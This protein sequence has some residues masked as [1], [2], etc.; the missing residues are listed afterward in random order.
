MNHSVKLVLVDELREYSNNSNMHP[1]AQLIQLAASL[2]EFGMAGALVVRDGVIGKGHGTLAAIKRLYSDGKLL[3]PPPGKAQG[4]QPYPAGMVPVIDA[5]GWT[6]AQF[7]AYVIADN[8]LGRMSEYD[9]QILAGEISSLLSE[10][11]NTDLLGFNLDAETLI[12]ELMQPAG[13]E[14]SMPN[15]FR[16]QEEGE[17][18]YKNLAKYPVTVILDEN[19]NAEWEALKEKKGYSDKRLLLELLRGKK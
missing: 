1:E 16:E 18:E 11:F 5:S 2:E 13:F 3:Y 12:A 15:N 7:R 6:D 8:N 9:D 19:E 17:V 10:G 14:K 4:A